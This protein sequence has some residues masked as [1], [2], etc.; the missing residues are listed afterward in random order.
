MAIDLKSVAIKFEAKGQKQVQGAVNDIKKNIVELL[1]PASAVKTALAGIAGGLTGAAIGT[2]LRGAIDEAR[3]AEDKLAQL[4]VAIEN[5]GASFDAVNPSID[6]AVGNI[7]NLTRYSDDAARGALTTLISISGRVGASIRALNVVTDLAAAKHIELNDAATLVGKAMIGNTTALGK[8]GI[9]VKEGADAVEVL[10]AKFKGFAE[11]D[12]GTLTGK[13]DQ[14]TNAWSDVKEA[15]GNVILGMGDIPGKTNAIRDALVDLK[16]YID[17]NAESWRK[18]VGN[19]LNPDWAVIRW[20]NSFS[21]W[22]DKIGKVLNRI[23]DPSGREMAGLRNLLHASTGAFGDVS[24]GS[25][26][27]AGRGTLPT[28]V[29]HGSQ[30]SGGGKGGGKVVGSIGGPVGPPTIGITPDNSNPGFGG[31]MP[32]LGEERIR[33]LPEII[34][35]SGKEAVDRIVSLQSSLIAAVDTLG[36][37]LGD[38]VYNAFSAAFSGGG[39]GGAIKAFGKT[40]LAG[41]GT[42][43]RMIGETIIAGSALMIAI[44][45]ALMKWNPAVSLAAG[46]ALVAIGGAIGGAAAQSAQRGFSSAGG[47]GSYSQ[48]GQEMTRLKFVDRSGRP[49]EA[50]QPIVNNFTVIGTHDPVAQRQIVEMIKL[51][52]RRS[53]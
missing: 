17:A 52:N 44:K 37:A 24:G 10:R 7:Q 12:A 16:T 19:L 4:R 35:E 6:E 45:K 28:V 8:M 39:F 5:T 48:P 34:N 51:H 1:N 25:S 30:S 47:D 9:K 3:D 11:A 46:I 31:Q 22:L 36:S 53:A 14:V 38:A 26:T 42:V 2:F 49:I 23:G 18:F 13:L 33:Q 41:L 29:V 27:T 20:L 43:F 21:G 50:T 32:T 15:I 40:I